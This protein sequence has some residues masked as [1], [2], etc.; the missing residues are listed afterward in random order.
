MP[1]NVIKGWRFGKMVENKPEFV[2]ANEG[3]IVFQD[4][5]KVHQ[6]SIFINH[7]RIEIMHLFLKHDFVSDKSKSIEKKEPSKF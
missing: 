6:H 1:N 2:E 5:S 3:E 7:A 4:Y